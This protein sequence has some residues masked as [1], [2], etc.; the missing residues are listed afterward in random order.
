[1]KGSV[2]VLGALL[3]A[4]FALRALET[5][6]NVEGRSLALT[7][8]ATASVTTFLVVVLMMY[9]PRPRISVV[10]QFEFGTQEL[11]KRKTDLS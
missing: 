1:M 4:V 5:D 7:G 8:L 10:A 9:T 2:V 6:A 11:R 3:L